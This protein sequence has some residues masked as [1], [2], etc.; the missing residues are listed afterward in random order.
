M[1]ERQGGGY[2]ARM[3]ILFTVL[4]LSLIS[5]CGTAMAQ[6]QWLDK[7]GR[8]VFSD[9]APSPDVLEKDILKRPNS[10]A[11]AAVPAARDA[12][13]VEADAS[14]AAPAIA[15]IASAPGGLDKDLEAKK[16]QAADAEAA[17]RK[18]EED[19]VAK[20]KVE[21]CNRAKQAKLSFDSGARISRTSASGEREILDDTARA[22]ELKHVQN[23]ID[24][25]CK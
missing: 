13:I 17:K 7:D 14:A 5:F 25:E 15:R 8:K 11:K 4:T 6:W 24:S 18:A 1:T 16:K 19:R 10:V 23:I 20:A 21:N 3:K 2:T 12:A 22:V 9:R